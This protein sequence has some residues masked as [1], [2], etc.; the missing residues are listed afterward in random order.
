MR[1][2]ESRIYLGESKLIEINQNQSSM[3]CDP[4]QNALFFFILI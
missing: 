2:Y 3:Q 1:L 4:Q